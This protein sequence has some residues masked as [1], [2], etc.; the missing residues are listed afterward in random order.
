MVGQATANP[1]GVVAAERAIGNC[2]RSS[3]IM[4]GSAPIIGAV[5]GEDATGNNELGGAS[6]VVYTAAAPADAV[7]ANVAVQNGQRSIIATGTAV[8]TIAI[9]D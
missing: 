2:K 5:A 3:R 8:M 7:V 4:D 1:G 9:N 6:I